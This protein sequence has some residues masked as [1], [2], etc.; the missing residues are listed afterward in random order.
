[1]NFRVVFTAA[2]LSASFTA[3]WAF[4]AD[5]LSRNEVEKLV[6][7]NTIHFEEPGKGEF[8]AYLDS[9]GKVIRLHDGETLEGTWHVNDDGALCLHYVGSEDH[10]GMV[11][12]DSDGTYT[13]VDDAN[14]TYHRTKIS[15]GKEI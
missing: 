12:K 13:R 9:A 4:A 15:N 5:S 10:C 6:T 7:G 3:S 1:M 11:K 2:M 8:R 14:V